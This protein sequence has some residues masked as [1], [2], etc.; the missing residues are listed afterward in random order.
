MTDQADMDEIIAEEWPTLYT[1]VPVWVLLSG[2]SAQAYRMYA[3]LAEHINNRTPGQRIAFPP[4]KAIAKVLRLKD[5]R[6]V[7]KYRQELAN[8]GAIRFK[9]FRYAGGMRRRY[10]YWVRFNPPEGYDGLLSLAQFY[11]ASPEVKGPRTQSAKSAAMTDEDAATDETAGQSGGGKKPTTDGGEK[12]TARGGE[13]PT[14]QQPDPGEPHQS[15]RDAAPSARSA[16]EARRASTGSRA[17][18]TRGSAASGKSRHRLTKAEYEAIKAVRSLLPDD[19]ETNLPVKTPPNLG[20][21][22]LAALAAGSPYERTPAQLVEYRVLKRWNGFWARKF[23]AGELAKGPGGKPS[24]VGPLMA[25]LKHQ[26]ECGDISCEDRVNIHTAEPCRACEVRRE[27]RKG[28]RQQAAVDEVEEDFPQQRA[29]LPL[30]E[31][32]DCGRPI[33]SAV[34]ALCR[35]CCEDA[36]A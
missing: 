12:P 21:A 4:Q 25:M 1:P 17:G 35:D 23:Y 27:D 33:R 11:E 28:D 5:Y 20:S 36:R 3:F 18:L 13:S 7:A 29:E 16:N 2:C 32:H 24:V 8:L 26:Q 15:D 31:C 30:R 19:L 22:I 10:R 34:P 9:E 6:D 14:A